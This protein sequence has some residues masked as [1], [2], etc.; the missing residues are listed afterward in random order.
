MVSSNYE[1]LPQQIQEGK[2][3]PATID[4]SVRRILRVKFIRGLFEQPCVQRNNLQR[5]HLK[6]DAVALARRSRRESLRAPEKRR[7]RPANF[8]SAKKIALISPLGDARAEMLGCWASRDHAG[9]A[10]SLAAGIKGQARHPDTKLTISPG[11]NITNNTEQI[12]RAVADA[13]LRMSSFSRSANHAVERRKRNRTHL[14]VP[15]N[16]NYFKP[17]PPPANPVI[18][19]LFN[20]RPLT[21]PEI[22][23]D[24]GRHSRSVASRR[25]GGNGVADIFVWRREPR[26]RDTTSFPYDVGQIP[27]HYQSFQHKPSRHW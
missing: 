17:S 20:G 2:V 7:Q 25:Q 14:G 13:G 15:G 11:C 9:D 12:S 26:G 22:N 5:R 21:I 27:I 1:T 3:S 23:C 24:C 8:K 18:V 19:V 4:E 10:I 6:P 16:W